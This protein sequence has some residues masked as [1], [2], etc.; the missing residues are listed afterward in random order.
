MDMKQTAVEWLWLQIGNFPTM[1]NLRTNIDKLLEQ[2]KEME[3]EQIID[4]ALELN[5]GNIPP[6]L[7]KELAEQYYNETFKSE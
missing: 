4:A 2:A 5:P 7:V 3:K 1:E 6:K